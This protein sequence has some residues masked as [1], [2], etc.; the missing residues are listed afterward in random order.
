LIPVFSPHKITLQAFAQRRQK[1]VRVPLDAPDS[2]MEPAIVNRM[3][4]DMGELPEAFIKPA[5]FQL[6]TLDRQAMNPFN[7][8]LQ[9]HR[10]VQSGTGYLV[11]GM[12]SFVEHGSLPENVDRLGKIQLQN[13]HGYAPPGGNQGAPAYE[14]TLK[15]DVQDYFVV[16]GVAVVLVTDPVEKS[17]VYLDVTTVGGMADF[18]NSVPNIWPAVRVKHARAKDA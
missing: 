10:S 2:A 12:K 7:E 13:K 5:Q 1:I 16:S 14:W 8:N 3:E 6:Q 15:N 4:P 11:S 17:A 9:K 18:H